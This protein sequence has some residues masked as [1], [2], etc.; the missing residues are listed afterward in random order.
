MVE[1]L[2]RQI[3]MV[4]WFALL[5]GLAAG[6]R[7][8]TYDAQR[9]TQLLQ[10]LQREVRHPLWLRD[11]KPTP[12][13][14]RLLVVLRQVED[15]GLSAADFADQLAIIEAS[16]EPLDAARL[17]ASMTRAALRL[18][19][20]LHD[21]RVDAAAA[22]Y[23]LSRRRAPIDLV[24]TM[25]TL[26]D[27]AD[28]GATLASLEPRS[29]QYRA[30]RL[31]LARYRQ[32]PDA[33]TPLPVA[34]SLR[35]GDH[36][37]GAALLRQRLGQLGD[38][39]TTRGSS[40]PEIYDAALAE[41]VA[42]FQAR[43]GLQ[44]DGVL[45]PRT[46][47]ALAVPLS[48][49]IRQI[50]LTLERWRWLPDLRAPAVIVN[51]PQFMLYTLSA[52]DRGPDLQVRKMSVIVGKSLSQTPVFDSAIE[53]VVFRPYWDVPRSIAMRELLPLIERDPGYLARH[54]MDIVRGAGE[55]AQV[56]PPGPQAI[57]A[58][59]EGRARLRQRPGPNN[60][61]GLIKFV[62]P[63]PYAVYLHDTPQAALFES[64]RRALSHG[65]VRVSDPSAL[66][67]YL[68]KDTP[69]DWTT[70]A[71]EAAT[72]ANVTRIV[73][74]AKPVPVYIL[75]GTA[76]ADAGQVLFFDDIYG[77]DRR[78]DALLKRGGRR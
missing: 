22:G 42:R 78:L 27:S 50:E 17:E 52:A 77:Y 46:R 40:S 13:A 47:A 9:E 67:A 31:A 20:Q 7:A 6:V 11:G 44:P 5:L 49:R 24:S 63:N 53:A 18:M 33:F 66:A 68:L 21:G 72:C 25:Q 59:R 26:A 41:G 28:V 51:V 43:H 76:V 58:L 16:L 12:Q 60:A 65:C 75:Y 29:S 32:L 55:R 71:I 3:P 57:A 2:R 8:A 74:L 69:G 73:R 14:R 54:E 15:F 23:R 56:L 36:Y 35:A 30:L 34:A 19:G 37:A 64:E 48:Q 4:V 61:L 45:G 39:T 38:V 62:L 1:L 10:Q 70:D